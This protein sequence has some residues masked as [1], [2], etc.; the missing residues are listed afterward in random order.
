LYALLLEHLPNHPVVRR[1]YLTGLEYDPTVSDS[2]RLRAAREWGSWIIG[3]AGGE[4]RR[5]LLQPLQD[6][7]LRVGYVSADFCQHTV[8]LFV[9]DVLKA[10]DKTRIQV[11][12]YSAGQVK[13]WVTN[14]IRAAC[15]F[16]D[17]SAVDDTALAE[18]VR[19]DGID[20]LVDLS[21]HTAG[22]RLAAF[23]LR[24]AP[25]MV[26]WL[27]YFATT[28]L[29][30]MD[31]VLLDDWHAPV[32]TEE[33]FVEPIVRL[34]SGRFCYQPV[35]WAKIFSNAP[36]K[37]RTRKDQSPYAARLRTLRNRVFHHEPVWHWPNLPA[38]VR[39]SETWLL[40]LNPDIAR[41]HSLLDRFH[42]I[43][44]AGPGGMPSIK[45]V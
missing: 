14:E 27:G 38:V 25:A 8:G 45:A 19:A 42:S 36:R 4:T 6:R 30:Y 12:A 9:K 16:R 31:A 2:E 3:R 43:H 28:G 44:A 24:P 40:W 35:S 13:D 1:N 17:V 15:V 7:P 33:Q 26:S 41:L 39:E 34:A 32:G 20:V 11:F 29:P 5:P 37:L 22:S 23:A 21:G 18:Q 10:H